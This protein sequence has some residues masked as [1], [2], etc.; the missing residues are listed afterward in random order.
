MDLASSRLTILGSH[1][2]DEMISS[3]FCTKFVD[4]NV[5]VN[6]NHNLTSDKNTN[7]P[8][9]IIFTTPSDF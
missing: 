8:T 3:G 1:F 9:E 2:G 4:K 5:V 7:H 6:T